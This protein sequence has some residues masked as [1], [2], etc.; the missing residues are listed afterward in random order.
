MIMLTRKFL[1]AYLFLFFMIC[2]AGREVPAQ[3]VSGNDLSVIQ[4]KVSRVLKAAEIPSA[5]SRQIEESIT[6][7]GE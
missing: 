4:E 2:C 5:L 3:K 1:C 6:L 7:S